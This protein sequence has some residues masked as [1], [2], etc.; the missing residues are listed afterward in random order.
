M[1]EKTPHISLVD[2]LLRKTHKQLREV[3]YPT[4]MVRL[5]VLQRAFFNE[6]LR[7]NIDAG[8]NI[9]LQYDINLCNERA[10]QI[11][12]RIGELRKKSKAQTR[13]ETIKEKSEDVEATK[14]QAKG[15]R[16][17]QKGPSSSTSIGIKR[18]TSVKNVPP[19][20]LG[21]SSNLMQQHGTSN[22]I[23]N[24]SMGQ[25]KRKKIAVARAKTADG[26]S[27]TAKTSSDH[28]GSREK[29]DNFLAPNLKHGE[30]ALVWQGSPSKETHSRIYYDAC[31]V[32]R[33]KV[34]A[35]LVRPGD[36]YLLS[37]GDSSE[38][39]YI[40]YCRAVYF[41][42]KSREAKMTAQWFFRYD[43]LPKHI[44]KAYKE[45]KD[46]RT[47]IFLSSQ[48]EENPIESIL[49]RAQVLYSCDSTD[50]M[51]IKESIPISSGLLSVFYC[52]NFFNVITGKMT[53]LALK[54]FKARKPATVLLESCFRKELDHL[55][56]L[57]PLKLLGVSG[58]SKG[59]QHGVH[60]RYLLM[61]KAHKQRAGPNLKPDGR[62]GSGVSQ[63]KRKNDD[64]SKDKIG[65]TSFLPLMGKRSCEILN[66]KH[67]GQYKYYIEG[68]SSFTQN[69]NF[70]LQG[71]KNV[72]NAKL[73][74]NQGHFRGYEQACALL[75]DLKNHRMASTR[76][77]GRHVPATNTIQI[78]L[79]PVDLTD[80]PDYLDIVRKPMDFNI[81]DER[82]NT[83]Q[84]FDDFAADV[85]QIFE[86]CFLYNPP[87]KSYEVCAL[88]SGLQHYF[89]KACKA[90]NTLISDGG[91]KESS[92]VSPDGPAESPNEDLMSM[93]EESSKP[94]SYTDAVEL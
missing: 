54:D 60:N 78:F 2:T 37:T 17:V 23:N 85:N 58:S 53:S 4:N 41:D 30:T 73:R 83:Y 18:K 34:V 10:S 52:G 62:D 9:S 38:K 80:Y 82:L 7:L 65:T 84:S 28:K 81:I 69:G 61:S 42:K 63:S 87:E 66:L 44:K 5:R 93:F 77:G 45:T 49:A 59:G 56:F 32:G 14:L 6:C 47:H 43:D 27:S 21:T 51:K 55:T 33:S 76:N 48:I 91:T 72:E 67:A 88:A 50:A 86:N 89:R 19:E 92:P 71:K 68:G 36:T 40:A 39:P 16:D 1:A 15:H 29:R 31:V 3:K 94:F 24:A 79:H 46:G 22:S 12:S 25:Q 57:F 20:P 35:T 70:T 13:V 11:V 8:E 26:T 64:G 74:G 75:S 90:I